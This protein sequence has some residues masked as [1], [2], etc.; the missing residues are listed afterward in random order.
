M[1]GTTMSNKLNQLFYLL[2]GYFRPYLSIGI[3]VFLF[4]LFFQPFA[5]D[6]FDYNNRLI[7]V[8]GL[9]IIIFIFMV[10]VRISFSL[11]FKPVDNSY[12][13]FE[14]LPFFGG[15][16]LFALS[17]IAFTFYLYY[18]GDVKISFHVMFRVSLICLAAP[19]VLRIY[20]II[21]N[22]RQ[23]TSSLVQEKK[24]LLKKLEKY[25]EDNL[26]KS[27]S[28]NSENNSEILSLP[29]ADVSFIRSADN[30]VEI[31]YKEGDIYKRKLIR[32]TLKGIEQQIK[33]YS[34]FVRCHRICIVNTHCIEKLYN[35][36]HNHWITIKGYD[37]K[38]PVSHP[39]LPKLKEMI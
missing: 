25:E 3:G 33:P 6:R 19:V 20:E 11:L 10:L 26:K 16:T 29:V 22:L 38:I 18:V 15:F 17:S 8:A 24:T 39:Y 37:E 35:S 21:S 23:L 31:V 28:F 5:L 27:I 2:K 13:K 12:A 30:Y 34:N 7:F 36:R 1:Y 32:N 4:V 9:G 14:L